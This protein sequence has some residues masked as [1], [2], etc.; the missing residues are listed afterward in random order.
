MKNMLLLIKRI[1]KQNH[2]GFDE[3]ILKSKAVE[4]WKALTAQTKTEC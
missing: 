1:L 2:N 4:R 3:A